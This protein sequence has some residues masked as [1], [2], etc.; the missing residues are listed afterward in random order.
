MI[1]KVPIAR[2]RSV[3][4]RERLTVVVQPGGQF[5]QIHPR[6]RPLHCVVLV[7]EF[8]T[9]VWRLVPGD[10]LCKFAHAQ[11]STVSLRRLGNPQL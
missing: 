2:E 11:H 3:D 7:G 8:V 4:C 1:T 9:V 5:R 10:A 6:P